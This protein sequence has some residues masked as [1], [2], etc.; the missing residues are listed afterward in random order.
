MGGEPTFV[1][2][3]DRD[4][5]E[6]NIAALGP[7]KRRRAIGSA[8]AAEKA[9]RRQRL[10]ALRTR[11]VVS[12]RAA[13]AMGARLLLARRTANR[14][15]AIR[16]LI[17]DE[18][19]PDG[20][21][22]AEAE[23]FLH[24]LAG[25]LDLSD[26]HVQAAFEDVWYY[27]WR[28]RRL[29]VNVDPFDSRLDDEVE[30]E[31]LR[32]VFGRNLD[33]VVGYALPLERDRAAGALAI[34]SVVPARRAAVSDS[35]RFA[36]GLSPA[37]RFA[38]VGG[39]GRLS[40]PGRTRSH[41]VAPE[42]VARSAASEIS[43][44]GVRPRA[45]R[46]AV[47]AGLEK[48]RSRTSARAP[49][50][51]ESAAADR[52][53]RDV[54]RSPRRRPVHLHA[55]G[56]GARGLPR[57]GGRRR[58]D[59]GGAAAL[60]IAHRRLSAAARRA[61]ETFS[62]HA[63][64]GRHRSQR[65]ARAR[66]GTIWSQP[67]RRCTTRRT[68]RGS[69]PRNSCSTA[70]TPAPA[71]ATTS[72]SADR[73]RSTA[74]SCAGPI[75]CAVCSRTGTTT[76]RCRTCSPASSSARRVR[77]RVSTRHGTTACTS[78]R[79]RSTSCRRRD[80][81]VPPWLVDRAFR[82]LLVDVSGNTHRAEFCIDK[83][84]APDSASGRRGLLE[85]RA[86]EMPP[87]ARMSLA[88]QL[89]LR[90]LVARFWREPYTTRLV[91]WGTELHDR[92]MLPHFVWLDFED[93]VEELRRA[94]YPIDVAWFLPHFEFRFPV[95]GE[96]AVRADPADP[97]SGARAVAGAWRRGQPPAARRATS[98][99]RSSGCRCTSPVSRAIASSSRATVEP[100]RC[101][102]R[103]GTASTSEACA[104]APGSRRRRC[105]RRFAP[106]APLTFDLVDTWMERSLGGCQYHVMHPGGR[107]HDQFPVNSYEA[108]SRR[109]AR[110]SRLG[111][112]P[113]PLRVTPAV[114]SREFP[115][116]LDLRA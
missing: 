16:S 79:S 33:S 105:I 77:R 111:H 101:S 57:A 80:A 68:R 73:R 52:P 38:A 76:R 102:R 94:G 110:F 23:R 5:P 48:A 7:T 81:N 13:A 88:Q 24:A 30:R 35:R 47:I 17:A 19:R 4:E 58:S 42:I 70:A 41:G 25:R 45:W 55:A 61:V 113:G 15:G 51:F 60:R 26:E 72:S 37:A 56:R 62:R 112:T 8:V 99:R 84:Y 104:I 11:Q 106:H 90:A 34:G 86:F 65:A 115:Y 22:A 1:S 49:A 91:R 96:V 92:F 39:G 116:T 103:D 54:R 78:S 12:G 71:A 46:I 64:S 83:L 28:E 59:G 10:R 69:P 20:H 40:V 75:C 63:R 21:G 107:S 36:D 89:L 43:V 29:P 95:A 114:P 82:H 18:S 109:L 98:T 14:R 93:V 27:L 97:A 2:I 32:R 87:H 50:R 66:D 6:W 100:C 108:E 85:L 53:H 9:L 44:R 31:R 74:R 67:R 3:D